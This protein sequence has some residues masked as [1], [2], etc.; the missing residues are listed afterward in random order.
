VGVDKSLEDGLTLRADWIQ[1]NDGHDSLASVG[2]MQVLDKSWV[3]E[4]W[5]SFPSMSGAKT[6]Y[7]AKV[8]YVIPLK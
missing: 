7:V 1:V 4:A 2:A 6:S 8:D 5:A 3:A